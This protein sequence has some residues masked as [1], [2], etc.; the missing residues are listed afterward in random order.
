M[1]PGNKA[2]EYGTAI[3]LL[4]AAAFLSL[5][6]IYE[7]F[8]VPAAETAAFASVPVLG[9]AAAKT[10]DRLISLTFR[11]KKK[12]VRIAFAA[13]GAAGLTVWYLWLLNGCGI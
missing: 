9:G 5:V 6:G 4:F 7:P 13:V 8:F 1:L 2:R 10:A 3:N 11:E 12:P